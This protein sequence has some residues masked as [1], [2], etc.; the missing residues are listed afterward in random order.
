[1]QVSFRSPLVYSPNLGQAFVDVVRWHSRSLYL[2]TFLSGTTMKFRRGTNAAHTRH[3]REL[4]SCAKSA[5]RRADP[6]L[7][8][9][10]QRDRKESLRHFSLISKGW[11]YEVECCALDFIRKCID[12]WPGCSRLRMSSPEINIQVQDGTFVSLDAQSFYTGSLRMKFT[13]VILFW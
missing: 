4:L 11:Y 5:A 10:G 13:R 8:L 7:T 2:A 12:W 9:R 6:S 3:K 1:M